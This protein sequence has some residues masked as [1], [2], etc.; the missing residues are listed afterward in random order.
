AVD[1]AWLWAIAEEPG[2]YVVPLAGRAPALAY[3]IEEERGARDYCLALDAPARRALES[4][5]RATRGAAASQGRMP[6]NLDLLFL[7]AAA[8]AA[9]L[10]GR[11]PRRPS[12]GAADSTPS[13]MRTTL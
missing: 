10:V 7:A 5:A 13:A 6:D 1:A 8:A 11:L 4:F 12:G 9:V 3:A 2:H